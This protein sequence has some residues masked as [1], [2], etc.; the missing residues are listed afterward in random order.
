MNDDTLGEYARNLVEAEA[1]QSVAIERA[2][3]VGVRAECE[4]TV[5][6]LRAQSQLLLARCEKGGHGTPHIVLGSAAAALLDVAR[7]LELGKHRV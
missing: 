5:I 7:L 6:F 3:N 2:F 1:R 4:R